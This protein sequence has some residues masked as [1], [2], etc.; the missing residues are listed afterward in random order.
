ME[1][2]GSNSKGNI[3]KIQ[4]SMKNYGV[5]SKKN[6]GVTIGRENKVRMVVHGST[7]TENYYVSRQVIQPTQTVEVSTQYAQTGHHSQ[8]RLQ[9]VDL[10]EML[11]EI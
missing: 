6:N 7:Q 10:R 2:Y 11:T 1:N 8:H 3:T 9:N 5:I 4:R